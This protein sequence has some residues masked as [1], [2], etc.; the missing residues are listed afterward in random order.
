MAK[1][2]DEFPWMARMATLTAT[3]TESWRPDA[4]DHAKQTAMTLVA[5][6]RELQ[7]TGVEAVPANVDPAD[8]AVLIKRLAS[9]TLSVPRP[10]LTQGELEHTFVHVLA[11]DAGTAVYVCRTVLHQADGCLFSTGT[12]ATKLCG[13]VLAAAHQVRGC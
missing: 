7:H 9:A 6:A 4:V 1:V 5:T 11:E 13:M 3:P 10:T 2:A 12:P 8:Y